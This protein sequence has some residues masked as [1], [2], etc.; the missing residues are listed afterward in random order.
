M[1]TRWFPRP[2]RAPARARTQV[3]PGPREAP[4]PPAGA[5]PTGDSAAGGWKTMACSALAVAVGT[6]LQAAAPANAAE[7]SVSGTFITINVPG[8]V[9]TRA[10]GINRSGEIVGSYID[11]AGQRTQNQKGAQR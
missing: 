8:A 3:A 9:T 7:A 6:L 11:A 2:H 1:K 10:L 4:M 5:G